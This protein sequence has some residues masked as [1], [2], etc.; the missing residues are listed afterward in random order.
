MLLPSADECD[1]FTADDCLDYLMKS[2]L[3]NITNII[4]NN[5]KTSP[6]LGDDEHTPAK[7]CQEILEVRPYL[8]SGDYWLKSANGS[9]I[10]VHCKMEDINGRK[11]MMSLVEINMSKPNSE[12]PG[13][14]RLRT[15]PTRMCGRASK[16]AGCSNAMFSTQDIPY[17]T[18][19][20]RISAMQFGA[21]NAFKA[22]VQNKQLTID[23]I[24][25]DGVVL[26]RV[27]AAGNRSH[28]WTFAA[29][30]DEQ[31]PN[32]IHVCPCTHNK[33]TTPSTIP[34]FVGEDYF[35]ET[36]T[37]DRFRYGH[38]YVDD[39]LWDGDGC[40]PTSTCCSRGNYFCKTFDDAVNDKIELRLCGDELRSNED[41]PVTLLELYIQ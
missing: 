25:V 4:C 9:S 23:D 6:S 33:T 36:G 7:S 5:T 35:C 18:V 39:P 38:F 40:G 16:T 41:S 32:M 30:L 19:C 3:D 24:Y 8:K 22:F 21:P 11:G 10:T 28:V 14:L 2:E 34:A 1:D 29:A 17:K 12:C 37:V 31:H 27:S 20:G 13:E 26:S 15:H